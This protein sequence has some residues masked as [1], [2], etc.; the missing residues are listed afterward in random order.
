MILLTISFG[1]FQKWFTI[2]GELGND[3]GLWK[4][5]VNSTNVFCNLVIC[6]LEL[7]NDAVDLPMP[8]FGSF[9]VG[10]S[11]NFSSDF[12]F[13]W[14][15]F[16]LWFECRKLEPAQQAQ[17][18]M[19]KK[20]SKVCRKSHFLL[21]SFQNLK[22]PPWVTLNFLTRHA[23]L[24]RIV[25]FLSFDFWT[26]QKSKPWLTSFQSSLILKRTNFFK[27]LQFL[28]VILDKLPATSLRKVNF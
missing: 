28:D 13:W 22:W 9:P 24:I 26:R 5:L 1:V 3:L 4:P 11:W 25:T 6:Q 20:K 12:C 14:N 15:F 2:C 7:L 19:S 16:D 10:Y 18:Q 27:I 17:L 21:A 23:T 8:D